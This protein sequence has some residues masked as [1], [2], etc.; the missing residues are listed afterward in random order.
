MTVI[1][2]VF[3]LFL[4]YVG[5]IGLRQYR[6]NQALKR[7]I[8]ELGIRKENQELKQTLADGLKKLEEKED[9]SE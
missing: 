8:E 9:V 6:C 3:G 4:V 7:G 5:F 1:I 2:G